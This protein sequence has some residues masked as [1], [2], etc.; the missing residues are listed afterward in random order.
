MAQQLRITATPVILYATV[1]GYAADVMV[2]DGVTAV[3]DFVVL[4]DSQ[5]SITVIVTEEAGEPHE[6]NVY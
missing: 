2:P 5:A 4:S 3:Q 6:R 1:D